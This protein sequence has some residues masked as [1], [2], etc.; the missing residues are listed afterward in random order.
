[1]TYTVHVGDCRDVLKTIPDC[2]IDAIVTDPPYELGFMG[3]SWDKSG[4]AYDVAVWS[5]CL[6]VLKPGGHLIAFGGSRTYH[7]LA[8]AIEDAGFEIRDQLQWLYGSGFPKSLDIS[9]ALD[10]QA[11][12][13][14]KSPNAGKWKPGSRGA[15]PTHGDG[16]NTE[17]TTPHN[18]EPATAAAQQWNGWGTALKPAHEPAVLAR[19]PFR[20][21]IAGN[22]AQWGTGGLNIDGTRVGSDV[23]TKGTGPGI[24]SY[25]KAAIEHGI[26]QYKYGLPALRNVN[27]IEYKHGRWPANVIIDETAGAMI[28]ETTGGASR[29]YYTAKSSKEEREAGLHYMRVSLKPNTLHMAETPEHYGHY[30]SA[31]ANN[32]PTVKPVDLMRYL[33]R[34]ITPPGGVVLDPFCGSGSTGCGAVV[35]NMDFIGIDITPEYADIARRRIGWYAG[36]FPALDWGESD[37]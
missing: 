28:D 30:S 11:G 19:K 34:L 20:G 31:R 37:E 35:E 27:E 4:I 10:K 15:A 3:K 8:V 16:W 26:R 25:Q 21:S 22:V 29:F 24:A 17:P 1:M 13:A 32:H 36:E 2:S 23:M 9:K 14:P 6:R 5:E 12:A 7:R 33:I 18:W